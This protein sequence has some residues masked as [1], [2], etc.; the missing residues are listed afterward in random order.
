[1]TQ[2]N[3][4]KK[5]QVV[6]V[7]WPPSSMGERQARIIREAKSERDAYIVEFTN[8]DRAVYRREAIRP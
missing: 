5:H 2:T 7:A 8:G 3:M 4:L 1:M 6:T